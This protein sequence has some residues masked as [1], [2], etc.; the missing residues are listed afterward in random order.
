MPPKKSCCVEQ[1]VSDYGQIMKK[2]PNRKSNIILLGETV[3]LIK[4]RPI[5]CTTSCTCTVYAKQDIHVVTHGFRKGRKKTSMR[6]YLYKAFDWK[7]RGLNIL[8]VALIIKTI[9]ESDSLKS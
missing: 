1:T 9:I 2:N 8:A 4:I 7:K 3:C 6:K 5:V